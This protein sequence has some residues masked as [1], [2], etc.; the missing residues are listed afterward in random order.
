MRHTNGEDLVFFA[1]VYDVAPD[2]G[3]T[4][5]H[6][7]ISPVRV[8]AGAVDDPVRIR[9]AGFA[10]RFAA[11]HRVRLVL[12]STDQTSAN[13]EVADDIAVVTGGRSTFTLPGRLR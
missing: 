6:R 3:E 10:H 7:L 9:L 12:C 8:P 1:K 5:I 11:G 4:L 13:S 2:G